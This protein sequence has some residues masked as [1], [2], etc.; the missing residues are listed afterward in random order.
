MGKITNLEEKMYIN[1]DL[2]K[3]AKDYCEFNADKSCTTSSLLSL[4]EI[5]L[6]NQKSMAENFD[7]IM[8]E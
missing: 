1:I 7:E 4:I 3:I 2:L 6:N 5:V 8:L